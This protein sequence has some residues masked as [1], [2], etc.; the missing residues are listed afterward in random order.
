MTSRKS[1]LTLILGLKLFLIS[2]VVKW[3]RALKIIYKGLLILHNKP[4]CLVSRF[5][6]QKIKL[7][8]WLMLFKAKLMILRIFVLIFL[9]QDNKQIK[10]SFKILNL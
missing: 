9:C 10:D 8:H 5:M 6:D 3:L 7:I 1:I 2:A 4:R